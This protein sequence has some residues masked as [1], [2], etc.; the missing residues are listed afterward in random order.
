MI[1]FFSNFN[2]ALHFSYMKVKAHIYA[3]F[4]FVLK[5]YFCAG[6]SLLIF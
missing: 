6:C 5:Y 4:D 3:N 2:F 1:L